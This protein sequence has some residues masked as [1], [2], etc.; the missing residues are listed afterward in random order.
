MVFVYVIISIKNA[1]TTS[2]STEG[3]IITTFDQKNTSSILVTT[4]MVMLGI[5]TNNHSSMG[6]YFFRNKLKCKHPDLSPTSVIWIRHKTN[7]RVYFY[8]TMI[9]LPP[10]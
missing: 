10:K 3:N 2:P 7:S 6:Y 5:P 1:I 8:L 4:S 9:E